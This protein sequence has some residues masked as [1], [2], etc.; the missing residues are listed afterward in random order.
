MMQ[1]SIINGKVK[2]IVK[3]CHQQLNTKAW[4]FSL[5]VDLAKANSFKAHPSCQ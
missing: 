5:E 4:V 2:G 1:K 3:E